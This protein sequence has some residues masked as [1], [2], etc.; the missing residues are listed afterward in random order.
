MICSVIGRSSLKQITPRRCMKSNIT[1]ITSGLPDVVTHERA[2][3]RKLA[4]LLEIGQPL[5][6]T[7]KLKV[8][9]GEALETLGHHHGMVRSFVMLLEDDADQ[10]HTEAAFGLDGDKVRRVSYR[11]G[12]GIVGRV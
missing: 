3:L 8:A 9:L 11:V 6:D 7:H 2:E 5:A 4:S 1:S 10:L 12:E